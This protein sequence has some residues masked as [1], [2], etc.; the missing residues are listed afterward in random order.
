MRRAA[1]VLA[2]LTALSAASASEFAVELRL[3]KGLNLVCLPVHDARADS[4]GGLRELLGGEEAVEHLIVM[5]K[6]GRFEAG[7]AQTPFAPSAGFFVVMKEARTVRIQGAAHS[8]ELK[9]RRGWNLTGAPRRSWQTRLASNIAALSDAVQQVVYADDSGRLSAYPHTDRAV[10][11]GAGLLIFSK[12]AASIRFLGEPW[13]TPAVPPPPSNRAPA[14]PDAQ[15]WG[16][17]TAGGRGGRIL[18]VTNLADDG[19][20]SF[21]RAVETP[22]PRLILFKTGGVIRLKTPIRIRE[23]RCTIAG[24][25]APGD[26][27]C[28]A[29]ASI[30][31]QTHD[32]VMRGLRIRPGGDPDGPD[33]FERDALTIGQENDGPASLNVHDIVIDRCSFSWAVDE[34][35]GIRSPARRVTIQRCVIAEALDESIHPSGPHSRGVLISYNTREVSLLQNLIVS[36]D[37]RNPVA[38]GGVSAEI[39]QNVIVNWGRF[40]T[41]L[42]DVWRSPPIRVNIARNMYLAGRDG[43]GP[44]LFVSPTIHPDSRVYL[45]GNLFFPYQNSPLETIDA[46]ATLLASEP[47][48]AAAEWT[49]SA[50]EAAALVFE[51]AGAPSR[52]AVDARIVRQA[53]RQTTRIL[54]SPAQVGGIPAYRRGNPP[55][56]ADGDGVPDEWER[57]NGSNP[58]AYDDPNGDPDLN[59]YTRIE[60]Y[61]NSL[62]SG[63][64]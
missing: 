7:S 52:D 54:D 25:T 37:K 35:I 45:E 44:A 60:E 22:G 21:R 59:G 53:K 13:G 62:L 56:D 8:V 4:I 34:L 19:P 47:N 20:G 18:Y 46:P 36:N 11:G 2:A 3:K 51:T 63:A 26:G 38:A 42:A 33:P 50:E 23:P 17:Q 57:Q 32:V 31:I 28:V 61:L 12:R 58:D 41:R 10:Y 39:V 24:Q 16:A 5:N 55:P 27:V 64:P 9:L 14:F 6:R 29:G 15:G 48:P 43:R 30:R 49:M 40:G 1:W